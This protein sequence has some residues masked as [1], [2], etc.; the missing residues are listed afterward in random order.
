MFI[1]SDVAVNPMELSLYL[2]N[3]FATDKYITHP[4]FCTADGT[5]IYILRQ[6]QPSTV[7]R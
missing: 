2:I 3:M 6:G 1:F 5:I 7:G 4:N